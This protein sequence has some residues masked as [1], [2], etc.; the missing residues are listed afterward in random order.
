MQS[1]MAAVRAHVKREAIR[2]EADKIVYA[3]TLSPDSEHRASKAVTQ[4][5]LINGPYLFDEQSW[6]IK[7]KSL[8]AGIYKLTLVK[9]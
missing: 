4:R 5:I 9:A 6:D 3:F 1:G 7:A 8:G 2:R